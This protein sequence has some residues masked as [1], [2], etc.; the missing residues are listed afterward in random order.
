MKQSLNWLAK[1]QLNRG[2][3]PFQIFDIHVGTSVK[4]L[5]KIVFFVGGVVVDHHKAIWVHLFGWQH[6]PI[7]RSPGGGAWAEVGRLDRMHRGRWD[8]MDGINRFLIMYKPAWGH[9]RRFLNLFLHGA[10]THALLEKD[11]HTQRHTA[12]DNRVYWQNCRC[13]W[14]RRASFNLISL[15]WGP[16]QRDGHA[17]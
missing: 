14:R 4:H 16:G 2:S 15:R 5:G 12:T 11:T 9:T 7:H 3:L 13:V 1:K 6:F 10:W 17:Q 8:D